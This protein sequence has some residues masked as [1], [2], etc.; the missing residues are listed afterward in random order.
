VSGRKKRVRFEGEQSSPLKKNNY[1]SQTNG[2]HSSGEMVVQSAEFGGMEADDDDDNTRLEDL[3]IEAEKY[4]EKGKQKTDEGDSSQFNELPLMPVL[5]NFD[6]YDEETMGEM[7]PP[8]CAQVP[9]CNSNSRWLYAEDCPL[10]TTVP[11]FGLGFDTPPG[12]K[13]TLTSPHMIGSVSDLRRV[14]LL[15]PSRF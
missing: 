4:Q 6:C 14:N 8:H 2:T 11:S 1:G 5:D 12:E 13:K 9:K 10:M 7:Y 15:P 3:I